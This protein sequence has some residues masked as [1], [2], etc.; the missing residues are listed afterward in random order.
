MNALNRKRWSVWVRKIQ[1][2]FITTVIG[3]LV[4]VLPITIFFTLINLGFRLIGRLVA[5]IGELFSFSDSINS[6]IVDL[7]A[8]AV[9]IVLFFLIGLIVRTNLGNQLFSILERDYLSRLPFYNTLRETVR[10][11]IGNKK[12]PFSKVVLVEVFG[13][14]TKMT[15]FVTD[16][17]G[18]DMYTVFVPTAPNP[19]NGFV[20]HVHASQIEFLDVK[21]E[22]AMRSII[23]VG[24]GSDI[25]FRERTQADQEA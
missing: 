6:W 2:F 7:V 11:F 10:Q 17:L 13:T 9:V 18:N 21:A 19:T 22:E 25:L 12:M 23:A 4:V 1:R 20:F 8:L 24:A 15:G 16:E 5:P 3:G 14:S